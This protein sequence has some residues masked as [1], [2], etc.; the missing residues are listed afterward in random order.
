MT[1]PPKTRADTTLVARGLFGSRAKAREAIEA[2][3]VFAGGVAVAKAS[4][5]IDPGTQIEA[6]APYPW[7]SRG[8]VK[9]AAGL[10]A[11]G[12]DPMGLHCLDIGASTGGFCHVLLTQGAA[13][14][15]AVDVGHGQLHA[16]L[17]HNPRLTSREGTDARTLT[18][19][20]LPEPPALIVCD[21]SFIS[22]KLILPA[23]LRLAA[24]DAHL[25]ALVKPQFEAGRAN[26]QKGIVRDESV[27]RAVC[28]DMAEFVAGLGW[29]VLG[30][31]PSP[32]A[33]GDGNR[34]FLLG[35]QRA[36]PQPDINLD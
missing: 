4:A 11:F 24:A 5:L 3:L 6:Q 12:I 32:I 13:H 35:A 28:A 30:I 31:T 10:A 19:A 8:G 20:D 15:T 29:R 17:H 36:R 14:V 27:H 33:G 34:E 9:L 26:V 21:A 16:S 1:P 25:V 22:L 18:A 2:G 7:V 23:V